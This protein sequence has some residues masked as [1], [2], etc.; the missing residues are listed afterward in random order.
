VFVKERAAS[1]LVEEGY[2]LDVTPDSIVIRA[3]KAA[4]MFYAAQTLRQLL[5][6]KI[7]GSKDATPSTPS[8]PCVRIEDRWLTG[9]AKTVVKPTARQTRR[10]LAARHRPQS[11]PKSD[12][13]PEPLLPERSL[14]MGADA[15]QMDK[16][17][18]KHRSL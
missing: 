13:S 17:I 14:P 9:L 2:V 6:Q 5:P 7:V 12:P 11:L 4:G 8:V 3:N 15:R 16:G 1:K 10:H 18:A